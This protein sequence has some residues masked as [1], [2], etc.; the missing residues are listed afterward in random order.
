M[1]RAREYIEANLA[2]AITVNDIAAAAGLCVRS[3]QAAFHRHTGDSPMAF[4]RERRLEAVHRELCAALP[5][6]TVTGVALRYGFGHLGRFAASYARK[7]G[8]TPSATRA[9]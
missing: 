3:L 6:T 9:G 8:K 2:E 1:R 5:G 4:L 7:F